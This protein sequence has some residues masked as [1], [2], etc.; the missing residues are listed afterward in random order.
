M[1]EN[2]ATKNKIFF[3][4][5]TGVPFVVSI[6][7]KDIGVLIAGKDVG[8]VEF[9]RPSELAFLLTDDR[10]ADQMVQSSN[11]PTSICLPNC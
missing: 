6:L 8:W 10:P 11:R 2:E 5:F 9:C 7:P 1:L 3:D 4:D